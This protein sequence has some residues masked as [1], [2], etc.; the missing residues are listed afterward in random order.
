[1]RSPLL[2]ILQSAA[3]C[4][5]I[6]RP[7]RRRDFIHAIDSHDR[8]LKAIDASFGMD[9]NQPTQELLVNIGEG[10][11]HINKALE[12]LTLQSI[13]QRA[14]E[15][16]PIKHSTLCDEKPP[17]EL[18][19]QALALPSIDA[20]SISA[21][22]TALPSEAY[23]AF[24]NV[25][26]PADSANW[27]WL[28]VD[29]KVESSLVAVRFAL[30]AR[31]NERLLVLAFQHAEHEVFNVLVPQGRARGRFWIAWKPEAVDASD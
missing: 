5:R 18:L 22:H 3:N 24:M 7:E 17:I 23:V 28:G 21:Y 11:E 1:M 12:R 20:E 25:I 29:A 10:P 30:P 26:E 2:D 4:E 15:V 6:L 31:V 19:K 13:E 16:R 27:S 8:Q 9:F 14:K